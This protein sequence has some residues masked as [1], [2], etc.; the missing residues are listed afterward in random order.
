MSVCV[1]VWYKDIMCVYMNAYKSQM[2]G[3]EDGMSCL[4]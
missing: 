2:K 4:N 1:I 3:S